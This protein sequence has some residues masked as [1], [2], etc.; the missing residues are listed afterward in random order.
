[1]TTAVV[2]ERVHTAPAPAAIPT[3]TAYAD[4]DARRRRDDG[5]RYELIDGQ[6]VE[7][8]PMRV[9]HSVVAGTIYRLFD[10]HIENEGLPF[11]A[12]VGAAFRLGMSRS[13]FRI[14]DLHVTALQRLQIDINNEPP[15]VWEGFPDIAV[16]VISP[17]D[18]Y[19]DV[20]AKARLYLRQ[21]VAVVLLIDARHREVAVRQS[22]GMIRVL[23]A[24]DTLELDPTLSGFSCRVTDIFSDLDRMA[25]FTAGSA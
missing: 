16:A 7:L 25:A 5:K 23:T 14:P 17:T 24:D 18:A 3:E 13:N 8:P 6:P 2:A 1:M 22:D 15:G 10:R 9:S 4:I 11:V 21:G 12:G 19:I 20:I